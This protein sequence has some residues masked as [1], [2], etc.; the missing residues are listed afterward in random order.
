MDTPVEYTDAV[1]KWTAQS[2]GMIGMRMQAELERILEDNNKQLQQAKARAAEGTSA[3][4]PDSTVA[5][6]NLQSLVS[7]PASVPGGHL[8]DDVYVLGLPA[9]ARTK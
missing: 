3:H 2:H 1:N 5:A 6:A 7:A 4:E 8:G 9:D